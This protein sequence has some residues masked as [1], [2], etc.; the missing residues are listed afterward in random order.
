MQQSL[1]NIQGRTIAVYLNWILSKKYRQRIHGKIN[2]ILRTAEHRLI[3]S[4]C[5]ALENQCE[6]SRVKLY[7]NDLKGNKNYF[8]LAGGLSYRWCELPRVKLQQMYEGNPE[9]IDFGSSQ[10][11]GSRYLESSVYRKQ[12]DDFKFSHSN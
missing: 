4:A 6:F 12:K 8:E 10:R 11:E 5:H 3:F 1:N 9:K 7:R 2:S